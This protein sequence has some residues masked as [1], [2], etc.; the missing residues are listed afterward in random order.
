MALAENKE[1]AGVRRASR[2]YRAKQVQHRCLIEVGGGNE[3]GTRTQD[4]VHLGKGAPKRICHYF[5]WDK[6]LLSNKTA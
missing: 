4:R 3:T 5:A 1:D 2:C 6:P